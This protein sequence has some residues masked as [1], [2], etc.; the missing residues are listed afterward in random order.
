MSAM[1]MTPQRC[2]R[3]R[4]SPSRSSS[5]EP[6]PAAAP[7]AAAPL[8]AAPSATGG[9][10]APAAEAWDLRSSCKEVKAVVLDQPPSDVDAPAK[11]TH[12]KRKQH[13][14]KERKRKE[15]NLKGT[16][17]QI[18]RPRLTVEVWKRLVER[19]AN[20]EAIQEELSILRERVPKLQRLEVQ[21]EVLT[22]T[23]AILEKQ[24][25]QN[26]KRFFS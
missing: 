7:S 12:K 8:A 10:L 21:N 2:I 9:Q 18:I 17:E 3:R 14:E 19:D 15:A 5:P 22:K 23:V 11:E 1:F 6:A 4:R 13:N 16:K 24:L 20:F 25:E 26:K